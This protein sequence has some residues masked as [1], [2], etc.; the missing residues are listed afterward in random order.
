MFCDMICIIGIPNF[1]SL[2]KSSLL[3]VLVGRA[4]SQ[5]VMVIEVGG[6]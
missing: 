5:L 6:S 1:L 4:I 2:S 3:C